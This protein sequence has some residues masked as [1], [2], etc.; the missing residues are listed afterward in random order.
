MVW[1]TYIA[2]EIQLFIFLPLFISIYRLH[3]IT[4]LALLLS[5]FVAGVAIS[6]VMIWWY[7]IIPGYLMAFD[8]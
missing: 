6:G 7:K 1:S 8:T 3:K 5:L 4:G 2:N